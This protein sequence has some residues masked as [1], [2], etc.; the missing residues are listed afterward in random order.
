MSKPL[1]GAFVGTRFGLTEERD[2]AIEQTKKEMERTGLPGEVRE[3]KN[4]DPGG[5]DAPTFQVL[6][7]RIWPDYA[8]PVLPRAVC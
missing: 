8:P 7:D 3:M 4:P 6:S 2:W 5:Y 1:Y